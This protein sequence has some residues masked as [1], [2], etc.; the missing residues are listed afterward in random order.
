MTD[1]GNDIETVSSEKTIYCGDGELVIRAMEEADAQVFTDEEL[2]QGWH[3]DVSKFLEKLKDRIENPDD[4]AE[5]FRARAES[6]DATPKE[7][8]LRELSV[9]VP[10][11]MPN[12]RMR[13]MSSL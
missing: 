4:I 9:L 6:V 5:L 12:C 10:L 3:T 7:L 11:V 8:S 13:S 1:R 2:A